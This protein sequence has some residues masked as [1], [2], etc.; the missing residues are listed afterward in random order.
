MTQLLFKKFTREIFRFYTV[1]ESIAGK[2][3]SNPIQLSSENIDTYIHSQSDNHNMWHDAIRFG[4][5]PR[6]W[7]RARETARCA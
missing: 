4:T 3:L 7:K 6:R 1:N 2:W 5:K